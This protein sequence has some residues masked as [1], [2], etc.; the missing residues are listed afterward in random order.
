MAAVLIQ[1]DDFSGAAEVGQCFATQGL[2]HALFLLAADCGTAGSAAGCP[3]G[4]YPFA[5]PDPGDRRRRPWSRLRRSPGRRRKRPVQENRFA[6]AGQRRPG[7]GRA[8][9][10]GLPCGGCRRPPPAAPDRRRRPA[11]CRRRPAGPN[12][13]LAGRACRPARGVAQLLG[14]RLRGLQACGAACG[15][16]RAAWRPSSVKHWPEAH[17]PALRPP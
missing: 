11:L 2:R 3:G 4:R 12:G 14:P 8:D 15:A 1:A 13:P 9:R 5:G 10:L 16:V 6:L 17:P 7:V